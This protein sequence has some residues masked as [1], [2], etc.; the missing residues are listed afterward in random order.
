MYLKN[1]SHIFKYTLNIEEATKNN[2]LY[3]DYT[4]E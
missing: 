4:V 1:C 2:M 3:N